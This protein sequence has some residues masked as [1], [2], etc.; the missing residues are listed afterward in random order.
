MC[1]SVFDNLNTAGY[2]A[3]IIYVL[4]MIINIIIVIKH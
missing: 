3:S 4:A 2:V 1:M